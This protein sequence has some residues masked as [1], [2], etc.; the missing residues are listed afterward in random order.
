[1]DLDGSDGELLDVLG[2]GVLDV[3][4]TSND[5]HGGWGVSNGAVSGGD[6]PSL[7]QQG[8]TA[9]VESGGSLKGDLMGD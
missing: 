3:V 4:D 1:M 6:D 5:G 7:I 2:L 8:T 9:I